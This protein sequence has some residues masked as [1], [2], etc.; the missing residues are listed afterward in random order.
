MTKVQ[1]IYVSLPLDAAREIRKLLLN[2]AAAAATAAAKDPTDTEA[3]EVV[4]QLYYVASDMDEKL[5]RK[6]DDE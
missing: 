4:Q 1:T 3:R 6:E 2:K 5:A